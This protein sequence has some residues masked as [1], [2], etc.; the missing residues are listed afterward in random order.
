MESSSGIGRGLV[1][2][3]K[4]DTVAYVIGIRTMY[5]HHDK[6]ANDG[7]KI[8]FCGTITMVDNIHT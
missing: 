7:R 3:L 1:F 4:E 2:D 8:S 5:G 6:Q